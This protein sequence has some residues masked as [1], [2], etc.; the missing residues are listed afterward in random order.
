MS[1][2]VSQKDL[3]ERDLGQITEKNW[4]GGKTQFVQRGENTFI[5][6]IE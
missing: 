2:R 1:Q 3:S 5:S 4:A 6:T